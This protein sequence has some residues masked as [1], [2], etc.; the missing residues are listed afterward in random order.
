LLGEILLDGDDH[1][2][3]DQIVLP[4]K[5]DECCRELSGRQATRFH[6]VDQRK[7]REAVRVD[8]VVPRQVR[9]PPYRD[10][11][12]VAWTDSVLLAPRGWQHTEAQEHANKHSGKLR[13]GGPNHTHEALEG[14][15]IML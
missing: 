5:G 4:Q 13:F 11:P 1:L 15:V 10:G 6:A 8:R 9:L 14:A 2:G 7:R 12:D 3:I